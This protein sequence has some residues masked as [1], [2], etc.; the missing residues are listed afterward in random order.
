MANKL[1]FI[2]NIRFMSAS[3]STL[4][5]NLSEIDKKE[6][7]SCKER[8]KISVNC[9]YISNENNV[10]IYKYKRY[11]KSYKLVDALKD[12]FSNTYPLYNNNINKS[13][14]LL[15]KGVYPY[16]YMNSWERFDKTELPN[17]ESFPSKLNNEDIT[18][19]DYVHAQKVWE[20]FKLKSLGEYHDLY[21]QSDTLLL[22]DVYKN[23]RKTCQKNMD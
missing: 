3:L 5:D 1:K 23:F 8:E 12:K 4:V 19:E 10:L 6:C 13:I 2:D 17:K 11:N 9:K 16:K 15:R 7:D 14:L 20:V 18:D 21:V 22:A